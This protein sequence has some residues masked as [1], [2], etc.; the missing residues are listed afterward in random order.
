MTESNAE[1]A[2]R[3]KFESNENT[4]IDQMNSIVLEGDSMQYESSASVFWLILFAVLL[5]GLGAIFLYAL[6][7]T[8]GTGT[9]S[10]KT[11]TCIGLRGE[12]GEP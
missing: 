2:D 5:V 6:P 1:Y 9:N 12:K 8:P 10:N 7:S 4:N 11:C 3:L